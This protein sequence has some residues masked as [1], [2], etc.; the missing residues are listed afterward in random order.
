MNQ[1]DHSDIAA[2]LA[3][4]ALIEKQQALQIQ[5]T[6]AAIANAIFE[7]CRVDEGSARSEVIDAAER[8]F[9]AMEKVQ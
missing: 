8:Y 4:L 7:L 5:S 3:N 1:A 6:V 9:I 2:A